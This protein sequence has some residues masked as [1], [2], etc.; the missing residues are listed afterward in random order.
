MKEE[1]HVISQFFKPTE[2][3]P[4]N[5]PAQIK[6]DNCL[7]NFLLGGTYPVSMV[8][9]KGFWDFVHEL[10]P[11]A[12][13]PCRTT[14]RKRIN[15]VW[16]SMRE[17]IMKQVEKTGSCHITMDIWSSQ[18]CAA[19]YLGMTI[20]FF[21]LE[22]NALQSYAVSCEEFPSPHTGER[23]AETI[24]NI[25]ENIGI[26]SKVSYIVADNG[27][28][29]QCA[30]KK[31]QAEDQPSEDSEDEDEDKDEDE[32]EDE[33]EDARAKKK[34]TQA[35]GEVEDK[36]PELLPPLEETDIEDLV[37]REE[38]IFNSVTCM[39]KQSGKCFSHTMQ[40]AVGKGIE[41]ESLTVQESPE[42]S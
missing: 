11:R 42:K 21:D 26:W 30:I 13:I 24:K 19:S 3:F 40:L 28:N 16:P 39:G 23:I 17:K 25:C 27:A 22:K 31:I 38:E 4:A 32:E 10:N 41:W 36:F 33:E 7:R 37:Q 9:D 6:I 14:M 34:K 1:T 18:G 15:Q 29:M 2:K 35:E 8:E 20:H 5:H 12:S